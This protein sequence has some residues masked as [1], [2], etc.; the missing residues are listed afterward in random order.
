MRYQVV[1][2]KVFI[3][4][5]VDETSA[6]MATEALLNE[7]QMTARTFEEARDGNCTCYGKVINMA[8]T[9]NVFVA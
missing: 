3:V 5:A 6:Q 1:E 2:T 7:M 4:E 8:E 9:S